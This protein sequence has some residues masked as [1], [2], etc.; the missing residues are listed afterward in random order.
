M[1]K[2]IEEAKVVI[3]RHGGFNLVGKYKMTDEQIEQYLKNL[4]E[5]EEIL[6]QAAKE[7]LAEKD[8]H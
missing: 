4:I 8:F 7:M 5:H 3:K 6:I 1:K 2:A